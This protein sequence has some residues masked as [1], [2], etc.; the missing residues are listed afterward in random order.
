[1]QS[2]FDIQKS[3]GGIESS[4]KHLCDRDRAHE[5]KLEAMS[6]EIHELA[7]EVHGAKRV[8]WIIGG[9]CSVIGAIGL[10]FL[11][12]ILDVVVAYASAKLPGH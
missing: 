11:N 10:V 3:L 2:N 6:S 8:A 5:A 1:L 9:I 4:I 12:K 7:K